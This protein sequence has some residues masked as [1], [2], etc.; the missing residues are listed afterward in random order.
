MM[1]LVVRRP[2]NWRFLA[3][4]AMV[5]AAY[6]VL[7]VASLALFATVHAQVSPVWPPMGLA[8]A[9]LLLWGRPYWPAIAVGAFFANLVSGAGAGASL[10]IAAGNTLAAVTGTWLTE[11]FARGIDAFKTGDAY[12]RFVLGGAV[13]A[14]LVSATVGVGSLAVWGIAGAD[15]VPRLW[16]HWWWGDATGALLFTP[17]LVTWITG[18]SHPIAWPAMLLA[19]TATV[20]V[21]WLVFAGPGG[22]GSQ[23]FPVAFLVIPILVAIGQWMDRRAAT[24]SLLALSVVSIAATFNGLGPFAGHS[25]DQGLLLLQTYLAAAA[26]STISLGTAAYERRVTAALLERTV[27]ERTKAL[28]GVVE[29]LRTQMAARDRA[30]ATMRR[31]RRQLEKAQDLARMGSW[32]RDLIEGRETW[33]ASLYTILGLDA[34][35]SRPSERNLMAPVH[36]EDRPAVAKALQACVEEG[37]PFVLDHRV[38]WPNGQVRD[39]RT[40]GATEDDEDGRPLVFFGVMIDTTDQ[41]SQERRFEAVLESAPDAMVIVDQQGIIVHCNPRVHDLF[42]YTAGELQGLPVET[43]IPKTLHAKHRGHRHTYTQD[44]HARPMGSGLDLKATRKDG[45]EFP[46]EI[47]LSPIDDPEGRLVV[48]AIRDI[49]NRKQAE[50][51]ERLAF[52]RLLEV[53]KLKEV[54]AFRTR[55]LNATSHELNTPITPIQ[56]QLHLLTSGLLGDLNERQRRAADILDRNVKRLARLVG[57]ILDV[58]R[59]EA[60]RLRIVPETMDLARVT[61]EAIESFEAQAAQRKIQLDLAGPNRLM[62]QADP[63]RISQVLY[64]LVSNGIKFSPQG[65]A[66]QIVVSEG[67]GVATLDVVDQGPGLTAEQIARLFKPF[68]QVHDA[69][70]PDAPTG[71]GLGLYISRGIVTAHGGSIEVRSEG[72]GHGCTFHVELPLT[73]PPEPDRPGALADADADAA[74][75]DLTGPAPLPRANP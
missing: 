7:A 17:L 63:N 30:Q 1:D 57:D 74:A 73:T 68:S 20:V 3:R 42:G 5:A 51:S 36:E 58:A 69:S 6:F 23:A 67:D 53:E 70:D 33:S 39:V 28:A 37:E 75:G 61:R 19:V 31:T 49:T 13:V 44:P 56:L 40:F 4:A 11:R 32:E 22:F 9:A 34:K 72:H 62:M 64:N 2:S 26:V 54:D 60:G 27:E 21:A 38:C 43:L 66:I 52:E 10:T 25:L 35:N 41:A 14:S 8:I 45:S 71:T 46:V 48:A 15:A 24:A 18:R 16:L 29:D 50:E 55:L 12:L 59:L 47:S 65:S